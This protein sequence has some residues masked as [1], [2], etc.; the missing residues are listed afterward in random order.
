MATKKASRKPERRTAKR[1]KPVR[2]KKEAPA[3]GAGAKRRAAPEG[4]TYKVY[5]YDQF[6][7]FTAQELLAGLM[8]WRIFVRELTR[9]RYGV[10]CYAN[11]TIWVVEGPV[12]ELWLVWERLKTLRL[13]SV[14]TYQG[15]NDSG[16]QGPDDPPPDP[17]EPA[18]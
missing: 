16:T 15:D 18:G 8:D 7:R 14:F 6:K 3:R 12:R 4:A 11:E 5:T 10:E 17:R 2:R 13:L 9:T 1:E